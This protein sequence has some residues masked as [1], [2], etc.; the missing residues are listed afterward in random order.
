MVRTIFKW[1][2][3]VLGC[4]II[5]YGIWIGV[6]MSRTATISVDYV[7]AINEKAAAIPESQQA[8]PLYRE[9]GIALRGAQEPDG[10]LFSE[11]DVEIPNWPTDVGWEHY[12]TW[13]DGHIETL[14]TILAGAVMRGSGFIISGGIAEED[15][16]LWP[17][18]YLSEQTEPADD[19]SFLNV[20]MPQLGHHRAMA[21]LLMFDAK[22]AAYEGD[23]QRCKLNIEA[24]FSLALHAREHPLLISDLVS[25][26]IVNLTLTTMSDIF[27]HEPFL[28]DTAM[29]ADFKHRLETLGASLDVR[30]E[31]ERYLILDLLQRMYTDDGN[32]DGSLVP[33]GI[34]AKMELLSSVSNTQSTS[35]LPAFAIPFSDIFQASRK[36]LLDEYDRRLAFIEAFKGTPIVELKQS[37]FPPQLHGPLGSPITGKYFLLELLMPALDKTIIHLRYAKGHVGGILATI[38]AIEQYQS[39]G[40]WPTSLG[41]AGI[42]DEWSGK[43]LLIVQGETHPVIYS[44]GSDQDDDGGVY[45]REARDWNSGVDG[46][47]VIWP[48]SE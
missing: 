41:G 19:G 33:T 25:L 31:G 23:A 9:A 5:V 12:Q 2:M 46:D 17:D 32:G 22:A 16:E 7:A 35:L 21:R 27:S 20:L 39:T 14:E 4:L 42:I 43:S 44:V 11:D 26:S 40:S 1:G 45:H 10:N 38:Y 47:W 3:M 29:L 36:E 24:A 48:T 6:A 13:L 37:V 15:R 8:W 34:T 28:F 30:F 18:Q